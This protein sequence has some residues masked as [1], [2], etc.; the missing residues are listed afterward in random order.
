MFFQ[1]SS[2]DDVKTVQTDSNA[3]KTIALDHLGV[4]AARLRASTLKFRPNEPTEE[5]HDSLK[6]LEEVGTLPQWSY[7]ADSLVLVVDIRIY[8]RRRVREAIKCAQ[9]CCRSSM[10]TFLRRPSLR[11]QFMRY[12][13]FTPLNVPHQSARELTAATWGQEL[14]LML[15]QCNLMVMSDD[16]PKAKLEKVLALG[17]KMKDAMQGVWKDPGNDI[18]DNG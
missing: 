15:R 7:L 9:E 13:L 11:R 17:R 18:F 2:L 10:Q 5:G 1:V 4:V 16:E 3:A 6:P 14:A 12:L 8:R